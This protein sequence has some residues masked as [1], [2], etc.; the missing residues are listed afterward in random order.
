MER[1][2]KLRSPVLLALLGVA[3]VA[4]LVGLSLALNRATSQVDALGQKLERSIKRPGFP[5]TDRPVDF[6]V[7]FYGMT[8]TGNTRNWIDRHILYYGAYEKPILYFMRDVMRSLAPRG[9]VFVDVGANTGQ[10][11][12]FM[13]AYAETVHAF[14]PFERVLKRFREMIRA[15]GVDNVVIHPV[16]LGD[17][18]ATIPFYGP[19]E[20]NL[21]TGSFDDAMNVDNTYLGDLEIV[22]GDE[23]FAEV[24]LERLDLLKM[25][26]EGF[27][28]AALAGLG[29]TLRAHRPVIV[30]ELSVDPDSE[31]T[32]KSEQAVRDVLPDG[33]RFLELSPDSDPGTG[34]YSLR[35]FTFSFGEKT[36]HDLV[37]YPPEK[38]KHVPRHSAPER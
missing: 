24:G 6:E 34:T 7:D 32:F 13:S 22:V 4:T 23:V 18:D 2:S 35:E 31:H 11:S 10:H 8:Y 25:D 38:A 30:M 12:L 14:E 29:D 15:N 3:V 17:R 5:V 27:E 36:R 20:R 28:K 26:I 19:A 37:A 33:Y 1:T 9:G 21:G 16:G